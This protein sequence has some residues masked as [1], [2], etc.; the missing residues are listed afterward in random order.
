VF[1]VIDVLLPL[2]SIRGYEILVDREHNQVEPIGEC[3]PFEFVNVRFRF[4]G[5]LPV[6]D[7]DA[8]ES[9]ARGLF[10]DR[11][12]RKLFFRKVP[13]GVRR[14]ANSDPRRPR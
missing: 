14:N 7:L 2:R 6:Q 9:Q 4:V 8:I 3:Q 11:L 10:H 1:R 5:H 12:N 13:V